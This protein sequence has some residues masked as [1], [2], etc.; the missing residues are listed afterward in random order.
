MNTPPQ[1]AV[2]L[3]TLGKPKGVRGQIWAYAHTALPE[4]LLAYGPLYC[5]RLGRD[6]AV[7]GH[8]VKGAQIVLTIDGVSDRNMA[9]NL[10]GAHL[11]LARAK[12]PPLPKGEYYLG[13]LLGCAAIAKDGAAIGVVADFYHNGAQYIISITRPAPQPVLDLPFHADFFGTVDLTARRIEI[14]VPEFVEDS[15]EY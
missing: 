4:N 8:E 6:V 12:L 15:T 1:D 3:A 11:S 10:R 9:E 13:D 7:R 14:F 2:K 5:D